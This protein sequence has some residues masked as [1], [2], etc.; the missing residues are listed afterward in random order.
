MAQSGIVFDRAY[1]A[2]PE[3]IKGL[4]SILS[5]RYPAIET[6]SENY[7]HIGKP[8]LAHAL[9]AEG[10]RTALFH[11]GRFM[12]LGMEDVIQDRG[13]EQ[14]FDAGAIGGQRESSF[15]VEEPATVERMLEWLKQLPADEPFFL[16]YLPT[17]GHHPYLTPEAGPF[18]EE[19]DAQR[20]LNALHYGDQALG[21]LLKE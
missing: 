1:A 16:T 13:Y 18:S 10:Y 15:G 6:S 5:S 21:Q 8:S 20:Y 7:R 3:S 9:R 2:Y 17:A 19:T 4:F 12:Y 14:L 11:S